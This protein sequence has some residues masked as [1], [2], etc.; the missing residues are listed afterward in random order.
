MA[1]QDQIPLFLAASGSGR[2]DAIGGFLIGVSVL[3]LLMFLLLIIA[4]V[5]RFHAGGRAPEPTTGAPG[6]QF[7]LGTAA[8]GL[9]ILLFV[10]SVRA[11]PP[12]AAAHPHPLDIRIVAKQWIWKVQH[13]EGQR[14]LNELHIPV[15]VPIRL[16][17]SSQ[18]VVHGLFIPALG[19][20]RA[21]VPGREATEWFQ[22]DR[23]GEFRFL[24]SQ[25]CGTNHSLMSGTVH[26]T[27]APA[28]EQWLAGGV[29]DQTP[30]EAGETLFRAFRCDTCHNSDPKATGPKLAGAFGEPVK[31]KDGTTVMF[32]DAYAR[33]SILEPAA[34]VV[35]GFEPVMQPYRGQLNEEQVAQIIAYLKSLK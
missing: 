21:V 34:R 13:P 1:V 17:L 4:F 32:D 15:N 19:V 29:R 10:W 28:Y 7:V 24:C 16:T 23:T 27:S 25:F 30:E 11:A 9:A 18:D 8:F 22:A 35:A 2:I 20:Q 14:E 3:T 5:V 6:F 12:G 33:E 26:V 31:L